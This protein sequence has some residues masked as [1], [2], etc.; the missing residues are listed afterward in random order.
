M[1]HEKIETTLRYV[2]VSNGQKHDAIAR[3]FGQQAGNASTARP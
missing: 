3:A 1:G 2:T